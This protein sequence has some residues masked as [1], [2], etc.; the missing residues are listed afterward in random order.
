MVK[1][2]LLVDLEHKER[3]LKEMKKLHSINE[4]KVKASIETK[5]KIATEH[6]ADL[7]KLRTKIKALKTEIDR[8]N[9]LLALEDEAFKQLKSK[10]DVEISRLL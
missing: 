8:K 5:K 6:Q 3:T 7:H 2:D 1:K 9:Q 10:Y 4:D